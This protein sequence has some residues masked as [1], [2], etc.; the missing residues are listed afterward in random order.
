MRKHDEKYATMTAHELCD[1]IGQ[2]P[3]REGGLLKISCYNTA[4]HK[5]GDRHPS[6]TVYGYADGKDRGF[7][8]F[9]CGESGTNSWLLKQY[10]VRED[11]SM[12]LKTQQRVEIERE[13][14]VMELPDSYTNRLQAI[15]ESLPGLPDAAKKHLEAKGFEPELYEE[16]GW[17]WHTDQIKGIKQP[18]GSV[19]GKWGAGIFMPYWFNGKM[20]TARLRTLNGDKIS[21]KGNK[22][23]EHPSWPYNLDAVM[24]HKRVFV[25]EG[26]TDTLTINFVQQDIPAVGIPGATSGPAIERL[27]EQAAS[28]NTQLIVIPDNDKAGE[29]MLNRIRKLAWDYRLAVDVARLP[30]GKDVNEWYQQ[31]SPEEVQLFFDRYSVKKPVPLPKQPDQLEPV[32]SIFGDVELLVA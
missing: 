15:W 9:G 19:K 3:R 1:R 6:L 25:T 31:A 27:I 29:N 20:V 12:P 4:G 22:I 7:Y 5:H 8:C 16:W 18:D 2:Q 23:D 11:G 17:R 14:P 10:G 26:E 24:T 32:R 28:Y 21:L 13:K 30:S